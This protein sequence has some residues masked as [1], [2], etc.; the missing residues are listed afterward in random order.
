M[1]ASKVEG[2]SFVCNGTRVNEVTCIAGYLCPDVLG[3]MIVILFQIESVSV[4]KQKL[5]IAPSSL[6]SFTKPRQFV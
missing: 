2:R 4:I 3:R 1:Y 6:F 5:T